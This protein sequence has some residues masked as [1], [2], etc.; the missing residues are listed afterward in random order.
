MLIFST[1][2]NFVGFWLIGTSIGAALTFSNSFGAAFKGDDGRGS[3]E[4]DDD[5]RLG[6][7]R[8]G[9]MGVAGLWWGLVI[10]ISATSIVGIINLSRMNFRDEVRLAKERVRDN[11]DDRE[12]GRCKT[13]NKRNGAGAGAVVV[14]AGQA[15]DDYDI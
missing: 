3:E 8:K 11:G 4:E 2:Q 10:G 5:D 6:G 1:K 15:T 13:T 7:S 9:S 14:A 12:R